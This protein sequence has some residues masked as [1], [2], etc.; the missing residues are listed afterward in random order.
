MKRVESWQKSAH[1]DLR[2]RSIHVLKRLTMISIRHV[3]IRFNSFD[4]QRR[5]YLFAFLSCS[6][7]AIVWLHH[8]YKN[9]MRKTD[10]S[11][12]DA[13]EIALRIDFL[14]CLNAHTTATSTTWDA[15]WTFWIFDSRLSNED[16]EKQNVFKKSFW[17]ILKSN[18]HSKIHIFDFIRQKCRL[19]ITF[20]YIERDQ[21]SC[22]KSQNVFRKLAYIYK[23]KYLIHVEFSF[24]KNQIFSQLCCVRREE[25]FEE[26]FQ[27]I[28]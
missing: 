15:A 3:E 24:N 22:D 11:H 20:T 26:R 23:K 9:A 1:R 14:S 4:E 27:I 13:R 10:D 21:D 18:F 28:K 6:F 7:Y 5:F 2:S 16:V 19:L 12:A 8:E 25:C 17:K